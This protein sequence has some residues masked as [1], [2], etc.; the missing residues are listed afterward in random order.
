MSA[1]HNLELINKA[2]S[3]MERYEDEWLDIERIY[4]AKY[5]EKYKKKLRKKKR[6]DL[7]VPLSR[8]TVDIIHAIIITSFLA[9]GFPIEINP[10]G[11][12]NKHDTKLKNALIVVAKK[13]WEQWKPL[14]GLSK[15]ILSAVTFPL[16]IVSL[17]YDKNSQTAKTKQIPINNI[18]FDYEATDINDVQ[19][20]CNKWK[21]SKKA[22]WDKI[23]SQIY[24]MKK[25]EKTKLFPRGLDSALYERVEIKDIY[26]KRITQGLVTWEL[27]SYC[28]GVLLR[29]A[30]FKK[31]P[32]HYGYTVEKIPTLDKSERDQ[33]VLVYG[34]CVIDKLR[35]IQEEYNIK[36]NQKIDLIEEAIDPSY[37][38]NT[39]N[40]VV[41]TN[42]IKNREKFIKVKAGMGKSI[43]D[44]IQRF[45]PTGTYA[46]SEDIE[47][48]DRDHSRA[49]GVNSIL[50]GET[51]PAD[52]RAASALTTVNANSSMRIET[53]VIT[54]L[55]ML[56]SYADSF[57][58]IV[59]RHTSDEDFIN[60]TEDENI[61]EV[62]GNYGRRKA[63]KA[64]VSVNFGTT[65]SKNVKVSELSS[66]LQMLLQNQNSNPD[67]INEILNEV[68]TLIRGEN[69][70]TENTFVE[71]DEQPQPTPE[72]IER[73]V[74]MSGGV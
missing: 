16:G 34:S 63:L 3:E 64:D 58:D 45:D 54:L 42:D 26:H 47:I 13:R 29:K 67:K 21:E 59:Y 10:T 12:K 25:A 1:S 62:V 31:S 69:A 22:I 48:L 27:F 19:Y 8:N 43:G 71:P 55:P 23:E 49:G 68:L 15:A 74:A 2:F 18:S 6:S 28:D 32:F 33:E 14:V 41:N 9:D 20:M 60:L 30:M 53:M 11:L 50:E 70:D 73:E 72:E 35:A 38:I 36:R 37:A 17:A 7:Y 52:R 4:K 56:Q 39:E 66:L 44:V 65:I 40:G 24:P 57:I 51:G 5:T 61:L 46:L